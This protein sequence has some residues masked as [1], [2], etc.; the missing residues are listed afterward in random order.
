MVVLLAVT[1]V[2]RLAAHWAALMEL[3]WAVHSVAYWAGTKE[4]WMVALLAVN[5]AGM[6]EVS[7]GLWVW[8]WVLMLVDLRRLYGLST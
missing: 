7:D 1:M 8:K 3:S 4:A 2:V 5:W 6:T